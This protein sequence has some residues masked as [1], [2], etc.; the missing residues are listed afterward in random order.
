MNKD[1]KKLKKDELIEIIQQLK[2]EQSSDREEIQKLKNEQKEKHKLCGVE[3][4]TEYIYLKLELGI[5]TVKSLMEENEELKK[6]FKKKERLEKEVQKLKDER[7]AI[8]EE[9]KE[10]NNVQKIKNER[11]AG[12]KTKF[13]DTDIDKI[14]EWRNVHKRS[15]RTIAK[16]FNCSVGLVHKIINEHTE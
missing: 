4:E 5:K 8:I 2:N 9:Y 15:I 1:L 12:R 6:E 3:N 7:K 14:L 16:D 10:T 11:N 13:T